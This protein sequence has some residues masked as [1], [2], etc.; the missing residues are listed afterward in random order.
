VILR[1]SEPAAN[2]IKELGLIIP[3]LLL[4]TTDEVSGSAGLAGMHQSFDA[5][6]TSPQLLLGELAGMSDIKVRKKIASDFVV[7]EAEL[8]RFDVPIGEIEEIGWEGS[9]WLLL[10]EKAT[11]NLF[12]NHAFHCSCY[13]FEGQFEPEPTTIE[14]LKSKHFGVRGVDTHAA[15][16]FI[17]INL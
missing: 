4:S 15:A 5:P 16:R 1:G 12:E 9:S 11:G 10:R 2:S 17:A 3:A 8:D 6:K 13:G 7:E 14:Y